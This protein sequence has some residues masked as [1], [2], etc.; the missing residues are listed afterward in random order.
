MSC[1]DCEENLHLRDECSGTRKVLT[2][3]IPL[4]IQDRNLQGRLHQSTTEQHKASGILPIHSQ[5]PD[6]TVSLSILIFGGNI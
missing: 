6:M 1:G 2:L 4:N 5:L 3:P